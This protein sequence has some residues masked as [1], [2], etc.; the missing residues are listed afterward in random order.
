V[1]VSKILEDITQHLVDKS[2]ERNPTSIA[3][4]IQI[5]NGKYNNA[6][7]TRNDELYIKDALRRLS[8]KTIIKSNQFLSNFMFHFN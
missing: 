2:Y 5:Q 7:P 6:K 8:K 3:Q 4:E 1:Y